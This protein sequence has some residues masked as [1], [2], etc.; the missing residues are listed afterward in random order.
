[1]GNE[2]GAAVTYRQL[3]IIAHEQRDFETAERWYLK[4]L[5]ISERM[6]N[7]NGAA[8]TYHQLGGIAEAR[9]DYETAERWYLKALEIKERMGNEHGAAITYYQLGTCSL[10]RNSKLARTYL[11]KSI[12]VFERHGDHGK[13]RLSRKI[14]VELEDVN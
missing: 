8:I 14:L 12:E 13:A 10:V 1:M 6:G 5:E 9:R 2:H 7:E 11:Q 3:G 4:S